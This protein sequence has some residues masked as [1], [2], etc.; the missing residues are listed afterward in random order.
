M[1]TFYESVLSSPFN[2][3]GDRAVSFAKKS[4]EEALEDYEEV[5]SEL[6]N[7]TE[8]EKNSRSRRAG[9]DKLK[10]NTKTCVEMET[11]ELK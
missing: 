10:A 3:Q 2:V 7:L 6:L 11:L 9:F 1:Y 4:A 8:S 5:I